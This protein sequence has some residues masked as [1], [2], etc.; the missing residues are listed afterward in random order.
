MN[1][2]YNR[3]GTITQKTTDTLLVADVLDT[4]LCL[5]TVD[6]SSKKLVQRYKS[7][8]EYNQA[9][10]VDGVR[11]RRNILLSSTDNLMNQTDR[12]S[13]SQLTDLKSFRQALRDFSKAEL[14]DK[15]VT[16]SPV[17]LYLPSIPESLVGMV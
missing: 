16:G 15:H 8:L 1:I 10:Y 9:S 3:F 17:T 13:S 2:Y 4:E 7:L 5:Y 6:V 12:L 11:S 14:T